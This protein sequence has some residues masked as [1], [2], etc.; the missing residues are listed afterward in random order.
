MNAY[1]HILSILSML[2]IFLSSFPKILYNI[3]IKLESIIN[4]LFK[5]N[6]HWY[7]YHDNRI[8]LNNSSGKFVAYIRCEGYTTEKERFIFFEHITQLLEKNYSLPVAGK[9]ARRVNEN[10]L[11]AFLFY[12]NEDQKPLLKTSLDTIQSL[13]NIEYQPWFVKK[14]VKILTWNWRWKSDQQ[15]LEEIQNKT[16]WTYRVGLRT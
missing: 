10:N 5:L 3:N 14:E 15:T 12:C 11:C 9:I 8:M 6:A 1:Y 16:H 7:H 13:I 2:L 4:N